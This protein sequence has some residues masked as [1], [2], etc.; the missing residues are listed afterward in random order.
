MIENDK[1]TNTQLWIFIVLTV[2]GV[3][4]FALP[5]IVVESADEDGW[6]SV[7]LGGIASIFLFLIMCRLVRKFPDDTIVEISRKVFGNILSVPVILIFTLYMVTIIGITLRIFGEVVKMTL[8]LRTP[9]EVIMITMLVLV[10]WLTRY[11]IEPIV[12]FDEF[13]FPLIM[14]TLFFVLFFSIPRTDF[15]NM[16]PVFGSSAARILDGAYK[17]TYS[18]AGF[19]L[20]LLIAP[21]V[22]DKGKMFKS[23]IIAFIVIILTYISVVILAIGKFGIIDTKKLIWPTLTM[24]RSI[25]VPGSF[26]E[27]LEGIVMSQ[28]IILAFTTIVPISYAISYILSR[29]F[30]HKNFK[31]FTS[32]SIPIIYL[33]S[34]IPDNIVEA[35][36]FL[37]K[38][39]KYL[40]T[41]VILIIPVLLLITAVLRKMG[42]NK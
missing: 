25:E 16:L 35:Y 22:K 29:I 14:V 9:V 42:A 31:H 39:T 24:I 40:E 37:D 13:V 12:R 19:E 38:I 27:R 33:I 28:W 41:P 11:G 30:K 7:I 34:L 8:L 10:I 20:I 32:I 23:G 1:I 18:Y 6:I 3:G 5:R 4:I 17:A 15:S 26:I 36:D 2:I 21:Q